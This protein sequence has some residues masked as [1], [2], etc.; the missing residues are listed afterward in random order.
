MDVRDSVRIQIK[1][2]REGLLVNLQNGSWFE[3][4]ESLFRQIEEQADFFKGARLALDVGAQDLHAVELGSLRDRLSEK[5]LQLWAVISSSYITEQTARNLGLATS[6]TPPRQESQSNGSDT[7][8]PGESAVMIQRTIRSGTRIEY[9][10]HVVV[11]GDVNPGAEITAG[12]SVVV[13]GK[14]RGVVHAGAEGD[15]NAV[16]CALDL[17]PMQMRI[18]NHI[19]VPP[20]KKGKPQPE[21]ASVQKGEVVA[22]PWHL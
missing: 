11:I 15:E 12:G 22:S 8:I 7:L 2:I 21:M 20:R 17:T 18:A 3:A 13:W 10:G 1:G 19:T 6:V 5:G 16:V 4:S 14:L 9:T